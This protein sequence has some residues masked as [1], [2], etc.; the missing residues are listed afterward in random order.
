MAVSDSS[1][2]YGR[3][4]NWYFVINGGKYAAGVQAAVMLGWTVRNVA[5]SFLFGGGG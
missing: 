2:N 3:L 1:A 5:N 4:L